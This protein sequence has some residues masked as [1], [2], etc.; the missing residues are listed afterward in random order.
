MEP[1]EGKSTLSEGTTGRV[2]ILTLEMLRELVKDTEFKICIAEEET[3]FWYMI[4]TLGSQVVEIPSFTRGP[5]D[6]HGSHE[7]G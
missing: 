2:T 4:R 5:H 1:V 3:K 7:Y 6:V